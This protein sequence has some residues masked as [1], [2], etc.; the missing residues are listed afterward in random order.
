MA[1]SASMVR[2][3]TAKTYVVRNKL[4][5]SVAHKQDLNN[6]I[7]LT[8]KSLILENTWNNSMTKWSETHSPLLL[9]NVDK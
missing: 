6:K 7:W 9:Q 8:L 5:I 4:N 2:F 1:V 3:I